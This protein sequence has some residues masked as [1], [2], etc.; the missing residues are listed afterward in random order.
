MKNQKIIKKGTVV[1][2]KGI[3]FKDTGEADHKYSRPVVLPVTKGEF[4]EDYYYLT[5]TS[6]SRFALSP[7]HE[8]DF[9]PIPNHAA[10]LDRPSYVNI[11]CIYKE[12]IEPWDSL[13]K[14]LTGIA[15]GVRGVLLRTF[16]QH[17]ESMSTP[18]EFFHEIET[19]V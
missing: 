15:P 5:L 11:S 13:P 1:S 6:C 4:D 8:D 19:L 14:V 10:D 16:K 18:D 7:L 12:N 2:K 9:F 3:V 17:Q